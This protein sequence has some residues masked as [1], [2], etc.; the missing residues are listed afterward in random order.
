[1]TDIDKRL[2]C[3]WLGF[4]LRSPFVLAASPLGDDP[5]AVARAVDAG[6]GAVVLRSLFE[7]QVVAEQMGVHHHVDALADRDAEARSFHPAATFSLGVEAYL[8]KLRRLRARVDVPVLAS[9]NG[10]TPGGWTGIARELEAAGASAIELNLYDLATDPRLD[11]ATLEAQQI[12]TVRAVVQ[13]VSIPVSVK[14]SPFY[15]SVPAFAARLQEAGARGLVLFNRFYQPDIDIERLEL[16]QQLHLSTPAELPLR[17]HA[18]AVLSPCTPLSLAASGGVHRGE[19]AA[20]A[21]LCGAHVV[22]LASVLLQHG[23]AQVA[24]LA[25]ELADWLD[26]LRYADLREARGVM[27]LATCPDPHHYERIN[28]MRLLDGWRTR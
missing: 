16:S 25:R 12:D 1:M 24:V 5:A 6:A 28:Y 3:D 20:R 27:S 4:T 19:D 26:R 14:I 13:A 21:V 2:A 23:P 15:A 10:A 9:L 18:L 7:E 8:E 11:G 22:Q 17:L